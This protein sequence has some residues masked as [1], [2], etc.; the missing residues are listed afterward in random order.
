MVLA[1]ARATTV[2]SFVYGLDP[3]DDEASVV[4]VERTAVEYP[5]FAV[6]EDAVAVVTTISE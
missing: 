6:N 5:E 2:E 1:V 4:P 3:E